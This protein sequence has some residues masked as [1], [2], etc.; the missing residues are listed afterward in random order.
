MARCLPIN[1]WIHDSWPFSWIFVVF[2][3]FCYI[4][5]QNASSE[6][7]YINMF[8]RIKRREQKKFRYSHSSV[9]FF[10]MKMENKVHIY[11]GIDI[12]ISYLVSLF[13]S[14]FISFLLI[15]FSFIHLS[16]FLR[17]SCSPVTLFVRSFVFFA[18]FSACSN[19]F[20]KYDIFTYRQI[21]IYIWRSV[22]TGA[23]LYVYVTCTI[24]F[25]HANLYNI[26]MLNMH[27]HK[28][29]IH[30]RI[31]GRKDCH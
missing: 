27:I 6:F 26:Y 10:V 22:H 21:Y 28:M 24:F 25:E 8:I 11:I 31:S 1:R 4:W 7:I 19:L 29:H 13:S 30:I 9:H 16:F 20:S 18:F 2:L 17:R 23:C 14:L 5:S 15:L 3:Y 12:F